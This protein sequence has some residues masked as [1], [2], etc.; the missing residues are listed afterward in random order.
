[1]N[2]EDEGNKAA[3]D[4]RMAIFT[5]PEQFNF[6]WKVVDEISMACPSCGM[7]IRVHS[8]QGLEV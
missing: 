1:M 4:R 2:E 7:P 5:Q 6:N 8:P 3:F